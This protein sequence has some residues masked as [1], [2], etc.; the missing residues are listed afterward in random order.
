MI[1][2]WFNQR[3]R[4]Q[5]SKLPQPREQ[6]DYTGALAVPETEAWWRAVHQIIDQAELESIQ[7]ARLVH[8]GPN[9]NAT[10]AAVGASEGCDLIR[11]KLNQARQYA[12]THV[13][14]YNASKE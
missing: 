8:T 9:T 4:Q 1:R 5:R 13:R 10:V 2:D 7:A 14:S 12:L 3:V 11:T 6:I